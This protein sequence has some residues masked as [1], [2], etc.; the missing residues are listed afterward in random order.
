MGEKNRT[1]A[2]ALLVLIDGELPQA[3]NRYVA[4]ASAGVSR[5]IS[6]RDSTDNESSVGDNVPG[7]ANDDIDTSSVA[8]LAGARLIREPPVQWRSSTAE[9]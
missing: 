7:V 5:Y 8:S 6:R 4:Y 9:A 3:H 2:P 1:E